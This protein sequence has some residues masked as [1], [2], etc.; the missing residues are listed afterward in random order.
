VTMGSP[1]QVTHVITGLGAGGGAENLLVQLLDHLDEG[2]SGHRV[3]SM[4]SPQPSLVPHIEELG[5]SVRELDW[6]GRP[7]PADVLRL[8]KALRERPSDVIQTWMLHSN[9]I[10]GLAARAVSRSPVIW[11]VHLSVFDHSSLGSKAAIVQQCERLSSWG[12]PSWIVACSTSS[13]RAMV[14]MHYRRKRI[15]TIPNGFDVSRFSPDPVARDEIRRELGLSPTTMVIGHSARYHPIKDHVSLVSAAAEVLEQLPDVRF[16]LCGHG[17]EPDNPELSALVAPLGDRVLVLGQRHDV[18]RVLNA[19]DLA[20]SSSV[21]EALSLSIGEAMAT[22]LP[23]VATRCGE[24]E[25]LIGN[26]GAIVP[27]RNPRALAQEMMRLITTPPQ[28]RAELGRRARRR[29]TDHYSLQKMVEGYKELW[30]EV[31]RSKRSSQRAGD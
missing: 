26:T 23:V 17:V 20:V 27:V 22:G 30:A 25:D 7:G 31:A 11:G 15:V 10:G 3:I 21:S 18:P 1:P 24:S 12:V 2:R 14:E 4:R 28:T 19:F 6:S 29:I 16:V 5:I 13:Y 9:V 8:G